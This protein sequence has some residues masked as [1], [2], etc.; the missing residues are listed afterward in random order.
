MNA[1][2]PARP[3]VVTPGYDGGADFSPD[4]RRVAIAR[5]NGGL[6]LR[7][8]PDGGELGHR[9]DALRFDQ[10]H[11]SPDG[12]WLVAASHASNLVQL[13]NAESLV[14]RW[15]TNLAGNIGGVAWRPDGREL[16]IGLAQGSILLLAAAEGT[17]RRE[18]RGHTS[19]PRFL[20]YAPD[21]QL[22]WSRGGDST[23]RAWSVATGEPSRPNGQF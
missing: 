7:Q 16:A 11:F 19:T 5:L 10:V 14:V 6:S 3:V 1:C 9:D 22:L 2:R 18:L 20:T 4:A 12:R 23:M 21:G 13:L 8:L 17:Q 15:Q